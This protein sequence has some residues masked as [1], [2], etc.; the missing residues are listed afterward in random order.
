REARS[1]SEATRIARFASV[2]NE[3]S[4]LSREP[5]DEGVLAEC[6]REGLA[7]LPYFPLKSGLLT[8]KYRKG[9]PI[10]QNTR[11]ARN[12]RYRQLLTD[13]NLEKIQAL[14]GFAESQKHS[15]LELAF[16]WLLAHR[17]VA[18]VIAG[19]SNGEQVRANASAAS[20]DLGARD[21]AQIDEL[22]RVGV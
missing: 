3:Y 19:A 16:S 18:S 8:G 10:P 7:F 4:L 2:Q 5:E 20:W 9:A 14:I 11:V 6:A 15:L 12:E 21:L 22:L 1:A 13:E 17:E